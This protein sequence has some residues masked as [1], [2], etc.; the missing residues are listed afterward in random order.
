MPH[1]SVYISSSLVGQFRRLTGVSRVAFNLSGL[2]II[3]QS[4]KAER[5]DDA[6][7]NSSSRVHNDS[8]PLGCGCA[9]DRWELHHAQIGGYVRWLNSRANVPRR[10]LIGMLGYLTLTSEL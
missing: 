8:V 3:K 2:D 6:L 4:T 5:T 1:P 10:T 7:T 9:E